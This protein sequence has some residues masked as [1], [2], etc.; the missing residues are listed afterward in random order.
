MAEDDFFQIRHLFHRVWKLGSQILDFCLLLYN[1]VMLDLHKFELVVYFIFDLFNFN[2]SELNLVVKIEEAIKWDP[3]FNEL[4]Y[5]SRWKNA[6]VFI[7][8]ELFLVFDFL[9]LFHFFI[10][11]FQSLM[12]RIRRRWFK[13]FMT[14]LRCL[15][16]TRWAYCSSFALKRFLIFPNRHVKRRII[17]NL[18]FFD[19]TKTF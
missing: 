8:A 18:F 1:G 16:F 14:E 19:F 11:R 7:Y 2:L 13:N 9:I 17:T 12:I 5:R 10:Q 4:N 15:L 3:L 6:S